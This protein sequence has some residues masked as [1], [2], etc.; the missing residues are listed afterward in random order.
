MLPSRLFQAFLAV[1][2]ALAISLGFA[3]PTTDRILLPIEVFGAERTTVSRTFALQDGHAESVRSLWL[4]IHGLRY[5]DQAS[6]Q[7]NAGA[8]IPLNNSTVTIPE[9]ARSPC[10]CASA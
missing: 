8:W 4:Q 7:V 1:L 3:H 2:A 9:P 5:A 6:V 10:N